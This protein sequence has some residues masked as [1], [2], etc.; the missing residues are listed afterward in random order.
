MTCTEETKR[1]LLLSCRCLD[2]I[3]V[4][5]YDFHG[6]WEDVTGFHNALYPSTK[7]VGVQ[8]QL[9]QVYMFYK[10]QGSSLLIRRQKASVSN[11][12]VTSHKKKVVWNLRPKQTNDSFDD[13]QWLS[14]WAQGPGRTPIQ[15]GW[16]LVLR[17]RSSSWLFFLCSPPFQTQ[18]TIRESNRKAFCLHDHSP[19]RIGNYSA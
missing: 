18:W 6:A 3:S 16:E 7:E 2:F 12:R 8:T 17:F 11:S 10:H 4:M 9:N 15:S 1:P 5:S 19:K 13:F 14:V